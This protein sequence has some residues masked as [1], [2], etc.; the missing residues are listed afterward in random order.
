MSTS[1]VD[2]AAEAPPK[3]VSSYNEWDPLEEVIVGV[4]EGGAVLP[5]E[6]GFGAMIPRDYMGNVQHYH[7]MYAGQGFPKAQ[8]AAAQKE[9]DEFV[10]ILEAEGVRVRRPD[11][12]DHARPFSTPDW[13]SKG[14]NAQ[15]NP[16][17]VLLVVGD[18]II[19]APMAWRARYF[20]FA[21]YRRLIKEYFAA[22]ARWTAAPKGI[23]ADALYN[24]HYE[25][26]REYVTTEVEPVFDAADAARFGKDIF[27]QRSQVTNRFGIDWLRRHLEGRF[28]VHE[29]E[30][31][32]ERAVHIDATFVPLAPGKVLINP[33]RPIKHLPEMFRQSGWELLEPPRT[34]LP[35]SHP[36]FSS[37]EWLHINMLSLDTER[38]IVEANEQPLI[39]ALKGW[40]FKPIP[41]PF[42][43]NYR[44]GGSFHCATCDV[45][46][47][48]TLM[49]YFDG[50]G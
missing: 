38:I 11:P 19:E 16:R 40:G 23:M 5:W 20:E 30:F 21:A 33:D 42:R 45:R 3:V 4:L 34:T 25:R 13:S 7:T 9:L 48:G 39:E 22:G 44:Y 6:T 35:R 15:A 24:K 46:R 32:D 14:G 1:S 10:H 43:N 27:V 49:S 31:H 17:D 18:E 29:V 36:S 12:I 41:C 47:K 37:F 28:N 50:G 8:R 2:S 26:G